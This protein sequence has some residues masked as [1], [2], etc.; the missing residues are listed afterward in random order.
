[1]AARR[2]P[3][4]RRAWLRASAP[5]GRQLVAVK[6]NGR[7]DS[8]P[9]SGVRLTSTAIGTPSTTTSSVEWTT[10]SMIQFSAWSIEL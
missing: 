1:M 9:P 7:R 6:I 5:L 2:S 3:P 8:P 4:A 10:V